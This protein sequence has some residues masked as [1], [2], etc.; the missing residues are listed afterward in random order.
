MLSIL[1]PFFFKPFKT[2]NR[3]IKR[4]MNRADKFPF[5][6]AT[7]GGNADVGQEFK[8]EHTFVLLET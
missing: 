2:S 4:P 6:E 1:T 8:S 7:P 3:L 5:V